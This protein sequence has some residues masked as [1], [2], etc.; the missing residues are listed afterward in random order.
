MNFHR[1]IVDSSRN[2]TYTGK[3]DEVTGSRIKNSNTIFSS[4]YLTQLFTNDTSANTIFLPLIPF[5]RQNPDL[6]SPYS[7]QIAALHQILPD[8]L[9]NQSY[10]PFLSDNS[11]FTLDTDVSNPLISALKET[12]ADWTRI[13]IEWEVIEPNAPIEGQSPDYGWEFYDQALGLVARTGVRIIATLS[14]SPNW[15]ASVPCAPIY[16]ERLDEYGRFL[17]DLVNHYKGPPYYINHWELVNE[18][19]SNRYSSG[20]LSGIGCWAYD[21]DQ[22]AQMLAVANQAIKQADQ[23][24]TVLM[25]GL[26]YDWF[27]EYGGPFNRYFPDDVME[28]DGGSQIDAFNLHYF[29]D[30][31]AEWN[32]WNPNSFDQSYD[33]IP[34]PTCGIVDDGIGKEYSVEG[35]DVVAKT[36][37]FR[38][39]MDTC[40]GVS[41]PIW[42]TEVG[43][44][45]FPDDLD[46][47]I[48]QA[49]YVIKV[50]ARALSDGVKNISW[51]SL[52]Q[53]P[54]DPNGQALLN[55]D[56][57][58]KP[59]FFAYQTLTKEM[60][61]YYSYSHDRNHCVWSSSGPSCYVEAYVFNDDYQNEKTIAWGK[62]SLAFTSSR[63]RVVDRNGVESIIKDGSKKDL[64]GKNNGSITL[65]LSDEPLFISSW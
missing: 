39:R 5:D 58:P 55:P 36:T 50:Y 64:D 41:K 24:A 15:A 57:Y 45:G 31:S 35:F 51:F 46:S 14:D 23:R 2:S 3:F 61:G 20:H 43:A 9:D 44:H 48:F 60:K 6:R 63:L 26:A 49:R 53:P 11:P 19:D 17:K 16:P 34:P 28:N 54:Y 13:R 52:D 38:N 8:A 62:R 56:F 1:L 25:G 18:P 65:K 27:E 29:T 10:Y 40:F 59:A 37:H 7:V 4:R 12:G 22:Y 33:W 21:G 32:R 42:L 30:F 47:L